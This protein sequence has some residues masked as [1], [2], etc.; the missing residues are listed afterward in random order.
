MFLTW[1]V[2]TSV[3]F[4]HKQIQVSE[5]FCFRFVK[6]FNE[7]C[8]CKTIHAATTE[9]GSYLLFTVILGKSI[10]ELLADT[11]RHSDVQQ[12]RYACT[13]TFKIRSF[14]RILS[15]GEL[16]QNKAN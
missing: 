1:Y 4:L 6:V 16:I 5:M 3:T 9:E 11:M 2:D 13:F 15:R 10:G 12:K 7:Y 8:L 14:S